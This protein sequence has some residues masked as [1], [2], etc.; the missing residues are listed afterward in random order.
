MGIGLSDEPTIALIVA[1][2]NLAAE[3]I[4]DL[5]LL[6]TTELKVQDNSSAYEWIAIQNN[7]PQ[8]ND[9]KIRI[10]ILQVL[11]LIVLPTKSLQPLS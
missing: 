10:S 8:V 4:V 1:F 3:T 11:L 9:T 6:N 7:D 5:M 2:V